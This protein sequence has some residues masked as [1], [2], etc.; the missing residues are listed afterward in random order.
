MRSSTVEPNLASLDSAINFCNPAANWRPVVSLLESCG[1]LT[2]S[3]NE[4]TYSS[5][6]SS[7]GSAAHEWPRALSTFAVMKRQRVQPNLLVC[8]LLIA[9]CRPALA[10]CPMHWVPSLLSEFLHCRSEP[11]CAS[12]TALLLA[13]SGHETGGSS[14]KQTVSLLS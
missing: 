12:I 1:Q 9:A 6:I 2:L 7:L 4:I 3:P 11:S 13:V 5:A 10:E 8:N 14:G